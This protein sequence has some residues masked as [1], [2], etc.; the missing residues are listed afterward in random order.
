VINSFLHFKT[1]NINTNPLGLEDINKSKKI[2]F[3]L[4]TRYGDTIIDLAIIQEFI[5]QHPK[6]DYLI[7]CPRQMKPYVDELLPNVKCTALNKRNLFDMINVNYKLKKWQPDIGFN[8]W[9][10][11]LDSCYFL[12]YCKKYLC[13]KD[14]IRPK[15]I[16]H[17][18]VVRRYLHLSEVEWKINELTLKNSYQKILICPQSTDKTRSIVKNDIDALIS[19]LN[20]KYNNPTITIASMDVYSSRDNYNQFFFKKTAQSSKDFIELVKDSDLVVCSD[21]GPLHIS[22]ALNKDTIAIF[23]TTI[24]EIVLNSN[25]KVK[26]TN[27]I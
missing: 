7:L 10:N 5:N 22:N 14:L 17:Y 23:Y 9:S 15:T 21:S 3:S 12:T 19:K 24:P 27:Q 6:K 2:L 8:P 25:S 4:F 16:N 18:Q 20:I 13:Y 1:K 26:I 11:G